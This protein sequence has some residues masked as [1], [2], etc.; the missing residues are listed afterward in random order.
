MAHDPS[1]IS[2][3]VFLTRN[4]GKRAELKLDLRD[5][6]GR[7]LDTLSVELKSAARK[8]VS[9]RL[10]PKGASSH[11]VWVDCEVNAAGRR[12][13]RKRAEVFFQRGAKWDDYD[14]VMYLFGP[15]PMPGLWPTIDAPCRQ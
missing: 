2:G 14:V 1:T 12:A 11:L 5:N 8:K 13:D 4:K 15:D 9:F 7:L 3:T 10:D 6:Y